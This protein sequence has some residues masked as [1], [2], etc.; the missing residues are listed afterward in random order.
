MGRVA[1]AVIGAGYGDEGKGLV[2]DALAHVAGPGAVVVRTN[3]GAQAGHSVQ[4]PNGRRH[5]F[6]HVGSGALAG[7]ATHLSRWFV[8]HPMVLGDEVA[9]LRRL[10]ANV[11]ITADPRG[12]V[13]TPCDM[14]VNQLVEKA[15]GNDRHGSCGYGFGET[16][17]RCE[18]TQ[19]RLAVADLAGPGLRDK[20]IAIRDDWAPARLRELGVHKWSE[21]DLA[22]LRSDALLERF[23]RDCDAFLHL[24][25]VA[26]D[27]SAAGAPSLI[28]E[29]AQGLMLDQHHGAF[30]Y[31]TRSNTGLANMLA[32]A[33]E[34]GVEAIDAYYVARCYLTRHGRGPMPN[35]ADIGRDIDV[36]D[37]T[38]RPNP[39]QEQLRL[40]E[41][42]LDV[43]SAAIGRDV[44]LA[45][46]DGCTVAPRVAV[47]CLDQVRGPIPYRRS[48]AKVR[49]RPSS[50]LGDVAESVGAPV[51]LTSHGPSRDSVAF[52][53]QPRHERRLLLRT[54]R[55]DTAGPHRGMQ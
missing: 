50:F 20:L 43:L 15:R 44:G 37:Q 36:V 12:W 42:D 40:G 2:V 41:L 31:V 29:G 49:G 26:P 46:H 54:C 39:W 30:P 55:P 47:T 16:V 6:H 18:E 1:Q 5:V 13:T 14:L 17:G 48:G 4:T 38:N 22:L 27:E 10:G 53:L 11:A 24:V 8:H 19:H 32:T 9:A 34:M 7:A 28:F 33:E 23:L 45:A 21:E 51:G 35:E 3:G 52:R 25:R